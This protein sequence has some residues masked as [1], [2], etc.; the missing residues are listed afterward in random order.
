MKRS[1]RIISIISIL[2][3]GICLVIGGC[4]TSKKP[5]TPSKKPLVTTPAQKTR[6][7]TPSTTAYPKTTA[8]R[9]TAE[10]MKVAGV[11]SAYTVISN[12][13]IYIGLEMKGTGTS[14]AQVEKMV[15]SKVKKME[16]GYS[17]SATSDKKTVAS[18]KR[19]ALGTA[20]GKP[21]TTFKTDLTGIEKRL[22]STLK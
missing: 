16:P 3:L 17:V 19:I 20:A 9:V 5:T 12:R 14:S 8:K 18:I 7:T 10:A 13:N 4:Q 21:L 11:R 15:V 6:T 1:T 22:K 2:L